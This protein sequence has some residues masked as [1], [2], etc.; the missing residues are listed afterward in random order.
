MNSRTVFS[1][2]SLNEI[3]FPLGGIGTGCIG[4]AGNGRLIDW[5]IFNRPGKGVYNG[6]SHFAVKAL[7]NGKVIDARVL[8]GDITRDLTGQRN[9]SYSYGEGLTQLTMAGFPHFRSCTF[10]GTLPI[11][12]IDLADE[13][14]PGTV[15]VT[16]WNPMIP[17]HADDSGIPA[18]FFEIAVT[19]TGTEALDY[20]VSATLCNPFSDQSV[21]SLLCADG[22]RGIRMEQKALG[23]EEVGFGDLTLAVPDDGT[24]SM[25]QYW[26]RGDWHDGL[27]TYWR[28]F[29]AAA[30]YTDR[31]YDEPGHKDEANLAVRR[32]I[33]PGET[34]TYR[35]LISWN[36]PNCCNYWSPWKETGEDGVERY[37][38]WKNYY[39]TQYASS[40]DSAV[41]ALTQWDR[42][43]N[44]TKRF[45]DELFASSLPEEVTEAV[46]AT[47][48]VL[49]SP[50]VLR[51]EHGEFY[52]WEGVFATSGSCEGT[53]T[54]VWNY[55]YALCFLFPELERSI[56]E[57]DFTYNQQPDGK[58]PFRMMLP[59]G[60]KA[61]SF[62]ACVDGQMGGIIKS[63]REWKISGDDE[64][65]RRWWPKIR[66][67]LEYT[68]SPDNPDRWDLNKDGV[69]EGRQHHT[70]DMELYGPSGW[71]EG[72]YLAAL[73]CAAEMA[74]HLGE[75]AAAEEYR[76]IFAR[77]SKW[78]EEHLFNG[79]WYAQSV[80]LTDKALL[81]SFGEDAVKRYW[82]DEAKEIKYQ[83]GGGCIIDQ[84]LGQWHADLC[85]VGEI[86]DPDHLDTAL[87][88]LFRN[89]YKTDMRRHFNSFRLYALNDESAAII[90]SFPEGTACPAIPI[91]YA[92]E[93]MHGFEYALAG[94]MAGHGM[95]TEGR[96][97]VKSIRD[98][99]RGFNRNPYN[100]IECGS[101]YARSMAS[102]GLTAIYA[103]FR[104]D[105][106]CGKLGFDPI[107]PGD[108]RG[109]WS[110]DP[111]WGRFE[112]S[113]QNAVLTVLDGKLE[114][115]TLELPQIEHV[116]SV[117]ADGCAIPFRFENGILTLHTTVTDRLIIN[118][119][120]K[121]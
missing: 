3:S 50:T 77:G 114:L 88:S 39:A 15:S 115:N 107:L 46:S 45:R 84:C 12:R 58:M 75:T 83:I 40:A 89:N 38:T 82:N 104:Y 26:Y 103:G 2:E 36:V 66:K 71:L 19:N 52:G 27:E 48:S 70:L 32:T 43:W 31:V 65:L 72:M 34:K 29:T 68:W 13:D 81:E 95:E 102:F 21:N 119:Q 59:I 67:S 90:C 69:L 61:W 42:L 37:I 10:T 14:F 105:M 20:A 49:K 94:L 22:V 47:L 7:R 51:L 6:H 91:P 25:Q 55:A 1:G 28:N 30:D 8:N 98:R 60:R 116:Q 109:I 106:T 121:G 97:I 54:H 64:W 108:F 111:A 92:S 112:Q 63:Y 118:E 41:Y 44:A 53:C 86:Y 76:S 99:Y 110:L 17:R 16:A 62:R 74:D 87:H 35:F 100:E 117:T 96:R 33:R 5:E 18:A 73:K 93:S 120:I 101:N 79:K 85:G 11:A 56:R 113:G 4:F 24:I 78:C 80:D 9:I 23:P 57:T